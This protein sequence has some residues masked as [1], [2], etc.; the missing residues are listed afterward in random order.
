MM[1][2]GSRIVWPVATSRHPPWACIT[3]N[4]S[5]KILAT[6]LSMNARKSDSDIPL[7]S[8]RLN[9]QYTRLTVDSDTLDSFHRFSFPPLGQAVPAGSCRPVPSSLAGRY[10][11]RLGDKFAP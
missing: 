10:V 9:P 1:A 4:P 6:V 11:A 3:V 5:G 7:P 8:G 2:L